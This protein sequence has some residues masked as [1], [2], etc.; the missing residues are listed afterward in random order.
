MPPP[1]KET[2]TNLSLFATTGVDDDRVS[3]LQDRRH[4][5]TYCILRQLNGT[6]GSFHEET[7]APTTR[8]NKVPRMLKEL[9]AESRKQQRG[10][11]RRWR[12]E[13]EIPEKL[14]DQPKKYEVRF[15]QDTLRERMTIRLFLKIVPSDLI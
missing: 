12:E 15:R 2:E 1:K 9:Y 10:E 5:P 13:R 4:D 3:R 14:Y 7:M 6:G 11:K 8:S